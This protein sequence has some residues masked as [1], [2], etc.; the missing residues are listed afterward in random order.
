M[1]RLIFGR[2]GSG[3]TYAVHSALKECA[4]GGAEKLMLLVPEQASF[5]NE[6]AMLRLLG[7]KDARRVSVMSF[8][9]LVDAVQRRC[10]G[11][12][13][14][15]LDDGGR[16][17]FMS[18]A[19]EQVSDR[20]EVF[21]KNA[22]STALV[23]L[24]L[25]IS[26]ELKMCGIT[27]E[28]MRK[29]ALTAPQGTL[30]RKMDEIA[31]ILSAYDSL[32]SQSFVD[33][34]DDLT[35]L[36]DVLLRSGF[37]RGWTVMA[38]SFQ[39][40]TAQEY[41]ILEVILRQAE[42]LCVT[43]C[44]DGLDGPESDLFAAERKTART[45]VR[46][47]QACGTP[48]AAPA[49]LPAG[50]R[51]RTPAL[52]AL[53]A[54]AY[55]PARRKAESACENILVYE[56]KN[57]Y[58]EAAFAAAQIRALVMSGKYRWRDFAVIARSALPYDGILDAAFEKWE[59]PYF[60][61]RPER[62]ET[63]PLMRLVLS[64]FRVLKFGYRSDDVF[65]YLKTGLAGL[66]AQQISELENY[67]FIWGISGKK[68]LEPWSDN[69]QGFSGS[70]SEEEKVL[71]ARVNE[72]REAVIGPLE[73][74]DAETASADGQT[75]AAACY[76]LLCSVN[77]AENLRASA[78]NLRAAGTPALAERELRVWD[79]LMKILD[80]TALVLGGMELSRERYAELLQLVIRTG[81]IASI[82]QGLD[83]VTVGDADRIRTAGPKVVFLIGAAQGAFPLAPGGDSVFSDSERRE[84]IRIGLPLTDTME[85]AALRERF[86]AYSAM[87][88]AS[89]RLFLSW[90][91]A[92]ED[93][94]G[95]S[96]SSIAGEVRAVFPEVPVRCEEDFSPLWFACA[97]E[98]ALELA[99]RKWNSNDP[100]SAS[101]RGFFASRGA[102]DRLS[103]VERAAERKPFRFGDRSAS[104]ALFGSG[105][106][107][108]ATQIE[109][110]ELCRFQYFCR[111]GLG[112]RE[113]KAAE[114]NV[115]EYGS[116][117][118][119]LLQRLFRDL[120]SEK[121]LAQPPDELHASILG[122]LGEYVE[123]IYGGMATKTPRFAYLV[124]RIADSAQ[125]VALH[126]ARELSQSGFRPADF[127]LSLGAS[128]GALT[129]PLPGGGEVRVDGAVD[130]VDLMDRGGVRYLRVV[131]YKTGKKEFRLSDLVYGLNMQMLIYLAALCEN[132]SKR[133]GNFQPAGVLY[134]PA[135]RPTVPAKRGDG[136][137]KLGA[138]AEG[139]LR[140]DGLVLDSPEIIRAMDRGGAGKYLPVKLKGDLP[141]RNDHVVSPAEL[142]AVLGSL[143]KQIA[144]M[145]EELRRGDV[146]ALP[147]SGKRYDA[148]KWCPYGSVCGH[149]KDD[150]VR[151]MEDRGRDEA[152]KEL[153][154][155]GKEE[156]P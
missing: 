142:E 112:A 49:V 2:A 6:R 101:L 1:L 124:S 144:S 43:V 139:G 122:F 104:R 123:K 44:A 114:L 82:P 27:P 52:A 133:Y 92:D 73:R 88:A 19:V 41:G 147:L 35:R 18:L 10:G 23:S 40:F 143:K 131:D 53:E 135:D 54:G 47:A 32:V 109:S 14:R 125:I 76:R 66:S 46:M 37:F 108:S 75:M 59:I 42:E 77:A 58:D 74:F 38:D 86:L 155:A 61:D 107:L 64:A 39:T 67:V 48:A 100:L 11:F 94:K 118:H 22:G 146:S 93:G 28:A 120:G 145:A 150:P 138:E 111:F 51:F 45:L 140:M 20:L 9:R 113:R 156:K 85:N 12:A 106:T 63:E 34:L 24:M 78:R 90:P 103:G 50:T 15:R 151:E 119:Y 121:I 81:S 29:A 149:E 129:V 148:C 69:P 68:W 153:E 36:R 17:V 5:E 62:V 136:E 31:L 110:F 80:Q 16:S 83:E 7:E 71:L 30:R 21:R 70:F 87:S 128:V 25:R 72:S 60:M 8:S 13:G 56:A 130:R 91:A 89:E 117:M 4:Q 116:L 152:M 141:D 105:T 115:L 95:L 97:E 84:L 55:R 137:E 65:L 102:E 3:K 96:P 26:A 33:P 132:G 98:P 57:R 127:E 79:L 134:M 99:A 126:I 154:A